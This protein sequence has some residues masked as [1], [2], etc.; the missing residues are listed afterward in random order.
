MGM[1]TP[2]FTTAWI[3]FWVTTRGRERIFSKPRDSAIVRIAS[4]RTLLLAFTRLRPLVGAPAARFENKGICTP[5]PGVGAPVPVIGY[6]APGVLKTLVGE[7]PTALAPPTC[8]G[9]FPK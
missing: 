7:V 9:E 5:V 1:R 3:L 4:K 6:D 8:V 2:C